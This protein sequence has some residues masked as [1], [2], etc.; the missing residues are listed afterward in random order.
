MEM[1]YVKN[2]E[3][4]KNQNGVD[5]PPQT[6]RECAYDMAFQLMALCASSVSF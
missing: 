2:V 5:E 1:R 4:D 6:L 3:S